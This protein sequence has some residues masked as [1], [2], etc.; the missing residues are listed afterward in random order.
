MTHQDESSI[1]ED[2]VKVLS[3]KEPGGLRNTIQ[4]LL[5]AAMKVEQEEVLKA[6]HYERSAERE[7]YRNGYKD[8]TVSTRLGKITVHVPQVRGG[9]AFYPSSLEKGIRSERALKL[10]IAEMYVKGVATRKVSAI[11]EELCGTEVSSAQVSDA[12]KELDTE[13]FAW[14]TRPLGRYQ[15]LM[16]DARYEHVRQSNAVVSS[17]FSR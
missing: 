11:V 9:V 14:R 4:V 1:L 13:I 3:L 7:A 16:L 8:K 17:A 12:A 6:D 10:A 2:V 15:Y 5:N